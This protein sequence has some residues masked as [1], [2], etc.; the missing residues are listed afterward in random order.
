MSREEAV[1]ISFDLGISALVGE[2]LYNFGE[3][4]E[5][6]VISV[7]QETQC[8][9]LAKRPLSPPLPTS[10]ATS[11]PAHAEQVRVAC[12]PSSRVQRGRHR[13]VRGAP[14]F[15]RRPRGTRLCELRLSGSQAA[16][17]QA[18]HKPLVCGV[19]ARS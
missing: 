16:L 5:H 6:P 10:N 13:A 15:A 8:A 12:A 2:N 18:V 14:A 17:L 9:D 3:L 7:L 11:F 19:H 4:L 1:T